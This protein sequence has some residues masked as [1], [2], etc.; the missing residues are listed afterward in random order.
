MFA[1]GIHAGP[2]LHTHAIVGVS[3]STV[4]RVPTAL[5]ATE[6]TWASGARDRHTVRLVR[7]GRAWAVCG[8]PY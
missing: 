8:T 2:R 5:V 6:L 4:D 1:T 3:Q 7:D